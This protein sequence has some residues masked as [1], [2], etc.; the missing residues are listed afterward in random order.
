M[1]DLHTVVTGGGSALGASV[2]MWDLRNSSKPTSL[3]PWSTN[4]IEG[5][6]QP[7]LTCARFIPGYNLVLAGCSDE[8]PAKC[9]NTVTGQTVQEFPRL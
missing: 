3:I 4:T 2:R 1:R 5:S 6:H 7:E 9:F 8:T